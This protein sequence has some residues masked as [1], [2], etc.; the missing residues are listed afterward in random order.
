MSTLITELRQVPEKFTAFRIHQIQEGDKKKITSGFEQVGIDDLTAGEVVIKVAYS[1]INYKDALAATGKGRILRTYPLVGGIDL[2]GVV[3]SSVDDRFEAGDKVLVCGAQLSELYDGGY[4]EYARV[5]ADSVVALPTGMS[6]RDAMALGTA[7][8][9]A[10]LAIQRMEDNG[11][12]PERGPIVVTGATGGVGSFAI[13]MLSNIGYEV[14]AFTGKTEQE[15]YLKALGAVK[16]I[17]RHDIE[18]GSKPLE[19]AQWGGAVDSVGGETLAWL[20]RTTHVW[21]NIASIGLAGGFKL[22]TT[23]MPFILRGVSLLGINS[24]EMPLSVRTQGWK[25]LATDLKPTKLDLISPT[26]IEFRDLGN[27]FDA[28]VDGTV[29][30]RTVVAID[31][32]L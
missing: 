24:V 17:S 8:Y 12:I 29:T 19:N 16:L 2:S 3:V 30:G 1:D 7:G 13:N 23:V 32:S 9:T 15:D 20:T 5:K 22:E 25:R 6:L 26:T 27:A 14:I 28:Y 21:G 31:A 10:A 11:Q 4:S 18:M